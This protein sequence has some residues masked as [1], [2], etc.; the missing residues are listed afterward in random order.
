MVVGKS[1]YEVSRLSKYVL[2]TGLQ[3]EYRPNNFSE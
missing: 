1:M 3:T 2:Q